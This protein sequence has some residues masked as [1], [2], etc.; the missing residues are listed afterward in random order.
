MTWKHPQSCATLSRS[1]QPLVGLSIQTC[2]EDKKLINLIRATNP[3]GENL[4]IIDAR[5]KA[6]AI[7]NQLVQGAGW[8]RDYEQC[9]VQFMNIENIH[10]MRTSFTKLLSLVRNSAHFTN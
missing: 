2:A 4:Y 10:E 1:S 9:V 3:Y 8:E 5:P 7:G 6:N